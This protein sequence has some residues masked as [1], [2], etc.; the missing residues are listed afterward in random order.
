M[1]S[2]VWFKKDLRIHDH[3]ALR[4]ALLASRVFCLYILDP[5][6]WQQPDQSAQHYEFTLASLRDL[7]RQIQELGGY[8]HILTGDAVAVLTHVH[9]LNPFSTLYS[10]EETGNNW[11]YQRDK[12]VA[13]WCDDMGIIWHQFQQFGVVRRLRSR[14]EWQDAWEAHMSRPL[15]I[16]PETHNGS[17][18]SKDS[19]REIRIPTSKELGFEAVDMHVRPRAG[20]HHA[21]AAWQH[22]LELGSKRYRGGIS[23]PLSAPTA[24]SRLSVYLSHGTISMR[25]LVQWTRLELE[26][27]TGSPRDIKRQGL[28]AFLSR[29]YWHCHFIQKLESEPEIEWRNMHRGYDGL[30]ENEFDQHKLTLW[31]Q[32]KTGW[33]LVDACMAMLIHQGWLN[34]RMRA[35]LVSVASYPL[36]LHWRQ[37]GLFLAQQFLDYEPGIHWSQIQMQS[38]T[39]GINI[40]RIYNPIKQAKDHDPRGEFVRRWCPYLKRVPD[41]WIFEPWR[42]PQSLQDKLGV[43][44]GRDIPRPIVDY[45]NSI[46]EAKTKLFERRQSVQVIKKVGDVVERHGSRK[47]TTNRARNKP[48]STSSHLQLG[49][50]FDEGR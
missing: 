37:T 8:L 50:E 38:G 9:S 47:R 44:V 28:Q 1:D 20:R 23:S 31:Q 48:I 49:F 2:V 24:C 33:P 7:Y 29:L 21:L 13:K 40:P 32:G 22:F 25:E 17:W 6:Q 11:S 45:E 4:Q 18:W 3:E 26:G 5:Q 46:R 41:T 19:L 39:T 36:W 35:L 27:L 10:H 30:R 12:Q 16:L 34:F 14:D 43:Y 42:M 15:Q